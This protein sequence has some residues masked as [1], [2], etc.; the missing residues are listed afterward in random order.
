MNWIRSLTED[1]RWAYG[2]VAAGVV[3]V[4]VALVTHRLALRRDRLNAGQNAAA[5]FRAAVL[6]ALNGLY[7]LPT[8][9]PGSDID[10]FLRDAFPMLQSAVAGFRPFVPVWRRRAFDRAWFKYR[11]GTG[12]EIDVQHYSHYLAYRDNPNAR[13]NFRRN[14]DALLSFAK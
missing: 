1:E 12:R 3:A 9:W 8:R 2:I 4:T 14:V 11:C 13:E 5:S 6:A 7:P 10:H